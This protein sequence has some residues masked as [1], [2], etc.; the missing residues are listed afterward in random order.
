MLCAGTILFMVYLVRRCHSGTPR[1]GGPGIHTPQR[2]GFGFRARSLRS[3]PGMTES[4]SRRGALRIEGGCVLHR[5]DDFHVAGAAADIAAERC[6]D[7]RF[8]WLGIL[9]Q[10]AGRG[11]DEAGRAIAALRAEVLGET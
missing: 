10:Q 3:R 5:L 7:L 11:H 1:S 2:W 6:D 8:G 4:Q 9:P